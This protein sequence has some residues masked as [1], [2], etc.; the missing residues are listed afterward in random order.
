MK[1]WSARSCDQ[2]VR[3]QDRAWEIWCPYGSKHSSMNKPFR[4]KQLSNGDLESWVC[5]CSEGTG[6][7]YEQPTCREKEPQGSQSSMAW[8][9]IKNTPTHRCVAV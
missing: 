8:Q 1:I 9:H 7:Y 2:D 5:P 3:E 4:Q 6:P